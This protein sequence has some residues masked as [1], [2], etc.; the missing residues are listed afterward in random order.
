MKLLP[1]LL[2]VVGACASPAPEPV[3]IT[4][5]PS[6]RAVE[7]ITLQ[8]ATASAIAEIVNEL[9]ASERRAIAARAEHPTGEKAWLVDPHCRVIADPRTNAVVAQGCSEDLAALRELIT[10]LDVRVP[11]AAAPN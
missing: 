5:P 7:V 4:P 1:L 2:L 11:P 9:V 6:S 3:E 8:Y 10:R